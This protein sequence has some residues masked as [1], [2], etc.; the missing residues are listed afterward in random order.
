[1]PYEAAIR[2]PVMLQEC[3]R[4]GLGGRNDEFKGWKDG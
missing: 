1:M 4:E 3:C 2:R